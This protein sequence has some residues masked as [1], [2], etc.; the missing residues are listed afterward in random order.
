MERSFDREKQ[1]IEKTKK[2]K[3]SVL[4]DVYPFH[5]KLD[6]WVEAQNMLGTAESEHL[7]QEADWFGKLMLSVYNVDLCDGDDDE[8]CSSVSHN[9]TN[10]KR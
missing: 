5:L 10:I 9:N 7:Q 6:I 4:M 3:V 8:I 2:T 1:Y